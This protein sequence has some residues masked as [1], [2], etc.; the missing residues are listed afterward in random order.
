MTRKQFRS[1]ISGD[2]VIAAG[3]TMT[4]HAACMGLLDTGYVYLEAPDG[5]LFYYSIDC[6]DI[7]TLEE[8]L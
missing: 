7:L 6:A 5:S 1:L 3:M 4:V 8:S 2:K